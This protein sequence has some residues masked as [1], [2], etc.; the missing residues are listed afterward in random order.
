MTAHVGHMN[1]G[2]LKAPWDDP[3]VAPFVNALD[4]V[5]AMAER[6]PGFVWRMP[7]DEMEAEQALMAEIG[8]ADRLAST[9]SVWESA[10][11]LDHFVHQTIGT[12]LGT[13]AVVTLDVD[14]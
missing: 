5:N 11:A 1:W 6:S 9:I 4:R 14:D 3:A 12:A 10:E 8:P 13:S 7:N 2:V